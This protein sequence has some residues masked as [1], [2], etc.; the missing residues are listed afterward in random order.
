MTLILHWKLDRAFFS[1]QL[2]R[3]LVNCS[4]PAMTMFGRR[5]SCVRN[6]HGWP[7]PIL[8]ILHSHQCQSAP[9]FT[10]LHSWSLYGET[11][12]IIVTKT[13]KDGISISS[14]KSWRKGQARIMLHNHS[15]SS[16][17]FILTKV[18]PWKYSS[19]FHHLPFWGRGVI[20]Q[21]L[22]IISK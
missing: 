10:N 4:D 1:R 21:V 5:S 18:L 6:G 14:F 13:F 11:I 19:G 17:C 8:P 12:D 16:F 7:P 2:H 9:I 22:R 3:N 15:N 20:R